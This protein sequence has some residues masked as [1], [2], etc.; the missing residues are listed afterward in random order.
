V[1]RKQT[2]I[3]HFALTF[4]DFEINYIVD[5]LHILGYSDIIVYIDDITAVQDGQIQHWRLHALPRM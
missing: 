1:A 5:C 3:N 4:R 2:I